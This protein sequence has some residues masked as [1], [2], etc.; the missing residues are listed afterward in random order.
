MDITTTN[1]L[2]V[3]HLILSGFHLSF[4]NIE[5]YESLW[6][7]FQTTDI[8]PIDQIHPYNIVPNI[9]KLP[10]Y[11]IINL[12]CLYFIHKVVFTSK[13]THVVQ[14]WVEKIQEILNKPGET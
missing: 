7:S 10:M 13:D 6:L 3:S 14:Q 4:R 5:I 12:L 8:G 2:Y 9:E 11:E 1:I